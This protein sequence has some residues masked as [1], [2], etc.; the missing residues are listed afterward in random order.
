MRPVAASRCLRC[1]PAW[2][3]DTG[4]L[5]PVAGEIGQD[6][7][8]GADCGHGNQVGRRHLL[9]HVLLRRV[10]RPLHILGRHRADVEEQDDQTAS[11]E[12]VGR[13]LR[14]IG[15]P[16][17]QPCRRRAWRGCGRLG[18]R[19]RR[20][21]AREHPR[22]D[23]AQELAREDRRGVPVDL[24]EARTS[25]PVAAVHLR[26]PR[27]RLRSDRARS[28]RSDRGRRRRRGPSRESRGRPAPAAAR[29]APRLARPASRDPPAEGQARQ[30]GGARRR[31]SR[32]DVARGCRRRIRT[33]PSG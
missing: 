12:L 6:V 28:G 14:R 32:G 19:G 10:D 20:R 4:N 8:C 21:G 25:R 3:S 22:F 33:G 15:V 30:R 7:E 2:L 18:R 16:P 26:R 27:S 29:T 31:S 17:A 24:L 5:R 13:E 9:V 1:S 11:D 23:I